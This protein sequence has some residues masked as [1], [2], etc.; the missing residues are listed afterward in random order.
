MALSED[1]KTL[2]GA[3]NWQERQE[4]RAILDS[5][6]DADKPKRVDELK[7]ELKAIEDER[8]RKQDELYKKFGL[9]KP[10]AGKGEIRADAKCDYCNGKRTVSPHDNR[11][12][13]GKGKKKQFTDLEAAKYGGWQVNNVAAAA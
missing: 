8:S 2:I 6:D 11:A 13:K 10:T 9:P 4:A 12:H 1:D 3:M 5:A 7:A